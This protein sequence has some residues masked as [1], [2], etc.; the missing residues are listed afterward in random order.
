MTTLMLLGKNNLIFLLYYAREKCVVSNSSKLKQTY[1]FYIHA[2][3]LPFFT[4]ILNYEKVFTKSDDM[5]IFTKSDD[6]IYCVNNR[7]KLC[8]QMLPK[9]ELPDQHL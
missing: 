9:Q 8:I 3:I 4:N 1:Q 5:K 7:I 2:K 6:M